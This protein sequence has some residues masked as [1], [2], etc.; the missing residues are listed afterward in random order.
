MIKPLFFFS[1]LCLILSCALFSCNWNYESKEI[2]QYR[3]C[4][5]KNKILSYDVELKTWNSTSIDT[6][7]IIESVVMKKN[8]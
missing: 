8:A 5:D 6:Y 4:L 7:H 1:F 3:T 2:E